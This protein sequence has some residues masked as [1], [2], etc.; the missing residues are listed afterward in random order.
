MPAANARATWHGQPQA[1]ATRAGWRG[2]RAL[3]AGLA[4][5]HDWL[6]ARDI[7]L[8]DHIGAALLLGQVKHDVEHH[9][10]HDRTQAA[11]P[12]L[13]PHRLTGDRHQRLIGKLKITVL[14]AEHPLIL[15][16]ER[17]LGIVEHFD[18]RL[19]VERLERRDHRESANE[20]GNQAKLQ[21]VVGV[22]LRQ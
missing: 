8:I 1:R 18:E 10:L 13:L 7:P 22:D 17:I 3:R 15:L 9:V 19:F 21:D 14:E 11:G 5:E 12:G 2:S 6:R 4:G 16:N 20:F